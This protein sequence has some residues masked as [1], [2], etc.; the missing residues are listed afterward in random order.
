MLYCVQVKDRNAWRKSIEDGKFESQVD[1]LLWGGKTETKTRVKTEACDV[2]E[3]DNGSVISSSID[4][5]AV[6]NV[7]V[8]KNVSD[9]A[10]ALLQLAQSI[11]TKYLK[12]PLG[13]LFRKGI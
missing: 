3:E 10:S 7:V 8:K 11:E 13:E 1:A 4:G 2:D 6:T 9:M 5:E 12:K